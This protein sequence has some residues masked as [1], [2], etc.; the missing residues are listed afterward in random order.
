[1]PELNGG[2]QKIKPMDVMV[3]PLHSLYLWQNDT[4]HKHGNGENCGQCRIKRPG[5]KIKDVRRIVD[6]YDCKLKTDD[7]SSEYSVTAQEEAQARKILGN[8]AMNTPF[9]VS[10][11]T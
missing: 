4:F 11:R 10:S 1:M 5:S 2:N 3:I 8:T 6:L 7:N 9:P